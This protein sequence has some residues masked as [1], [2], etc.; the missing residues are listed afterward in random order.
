MND[1]IIKEYL[2]E[3]EY[4]TDFIN[5][6]K[7]L[8]SKYEN[9]ETYIGYIKELINKN[10]PSFRFIKIKNFIAYKNEEVIGH[11]SSIIDSRLKENKNF[12]GLIGFYEC[13]KDD[14][15]SSLLINKAVK[16]L[17]DE[18]C[19]VIR[20]PIDLTIWHNY[21]FVIDQ[22]ETDSF[23]LEPLTKNYY[24][25]QFKRE[26][27]NFSIEYASAERTDFNTIL[28]YTKKDYEEVIKE[29]FVIRDLTKK[30]F[31][32]DIL[33]IYRLVNEIFQDSWSFVKISEEEYL[34]IYE[35]YKNMIDNILIQI[36]SDK[37]GKDIGF[38]SSIIDQKNKNTIVFKT[39]GVLPDY[40]N[41]KIGAALL[42]S[43]HKKAQDMGISNA[44]Y[45]LIKIDNNVSK[46]PYPGVKVIRKYVTLEKTSQ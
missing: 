36:I 21:R 19:D 15:L 20:A 27:F 10:N 7:K 33:S 39:I 45:A 41:K 44:I 13:I 31:K 24:V 37:N 18:N 22:K 34:Y 3:E 23:I 2:F 29:G 26:G 6:M 40:Q 35:D 4:Q 8:Y 28:D 12:I 17:K 1:Y 9:Y 30:S 14:E 5:L 38:C 11:I 43:K 46:L 25:D 32:D 16:Y 42:Y